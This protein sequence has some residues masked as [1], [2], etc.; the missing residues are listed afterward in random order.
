MTCVGA[1]L[2]NS[3]KVLDKLV[4][5]NVLDELVLKLSY[6]LNSRGETWWEYLVKYAWTNDKLVRVGKKR[7]FKIDCGTHV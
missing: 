3:Q 2:T 1:V 5:V 6:T 4:H 7:D